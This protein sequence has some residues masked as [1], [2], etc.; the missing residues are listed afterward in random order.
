MEK[1]LC[2][3]IFPLLESATSEYCCYEYLA[4]FLC[5]EVYAVSTPVQINIP[6]SFPEAKSYAVKS[7]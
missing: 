5:K 6:K 1:T 7:K 2:T 3:T 4:N